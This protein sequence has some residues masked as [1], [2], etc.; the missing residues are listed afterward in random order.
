LRRSTRSRLALALIVGGLFAATL[1]PAAQAS[2]IDCY[3]P[4]FRVRL[5]G[6]VLKGDNVYST[7]SSQK[8]TA[9]VKPGKTRQFVL[10]IQN[11]ASE[12]DSFRVTIAGFAGALV[13]FTP[14][15]KVGWLAPEDITLQIQLGTFTTP[16][17]APGEVFY[18]RAYVHA[19]STASAGQFRQDTLNITPVIYPYASDRVAWKVIAN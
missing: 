13:D 4:D 2:C 8:A 10:S 6:G 9:L 12:S 17:L 1:A 14:T 3:Q 15:Y 18:F 19:E 7:D 11:D 5:I 16:T